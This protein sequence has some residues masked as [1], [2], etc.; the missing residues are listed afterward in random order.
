MHVLAESK[1]GWFEPLDDT[2][3]AVWAE[4][5]GS[6][7]D[8]RIEIPGPGPHPEVQVKH[9]LGAGK[10]LGAAVRTSVS[11]SLPSETYQVRFLVDLTSPL[12]LLREVADGLARL[13]TGRGEP[14]PTELADLRSELGASHP[15]WRRLGIVQC[16][17][18]RLEDAGTR[19]A[20]DKLERVLAPG[21]DATVAWKILSDDALQIAARQG[22]RDRGY[23]SELLKSAGFD[24]RPVGKNAR[25]HDQL[26]FSR[27]LGMRQQFIPMLTHLAQLE[28]DLTGQ[29]SGPRVWYRLYA[30]RANAELHQSNPSGAIE[31]ARRALDSVPDGVEA[32]HTL[33][34]AAIDLGRTEEAMNYARQSVD[35]HPENEQAWISMAAACA[36][37]GQPSPEP[38]IPIA[39]SRRFRIALCALEVQAGSW[40]RVV[41]LTG[42]LIAE[43]REEHELL[44]W[45]AQALHNTAEEGAADGRTRR[46]DA[47]RLLTELI[48]RVGDPSSDV[49]RM[50][51]VVRGMARASLGQTDLAAEDASVA[52][53]HHPDAPDV[54]R[55]A[56]LLQNRIGDRK[57]ALELLRHPAVDRDPA[58]LVL[59][60][61]AL[62]PDDRSS[63]QR[64]LDMALALLPAATRDPDF[65]MSAAIVAIDLGN[66]ALAGEL[67][68]G[69]EAPGGQLHIARGLLAVAEGRYEEGEREF[70]AAADLRPDRRAGTLTALAFELL[71][72]GAREHGLRVLEDL[73]EELPREARRRYVRALLDHGAF[74]RAS[75]V[76]ERA[77]RE[78][79]PP[80]WALADAAVLALRRAD[81]EGA[82]GFF[83]ALDERDELAIDGRIRL[84]MAL[85]QLGRIDTALPHLD[86]LRGDQALSDVQLM[87]TAELHAMIDR[88]DV[89]IPL[90]YRAARLAPGDPKIQRAFAGMT[91]MGAR[92]WPSPDEVGPDTHVILRNEH[93]STRSYTILSEPPIDLQ[94][95]ELTVDEARNRGVLGMRLG[96]VQVDNIGAGYLEQHWTVIRITPA[97]VAAAHD[98]AEHY[99]ERFPDEPFFMR[100]FQLSEGSITEF[101]PFIRS[102]EENRAHVT[103]LL[104]L[105]LDQVVPLG[106]LGDRLNTGIA[107]LVE[108]LSSDPLVGKLHVEWID[109]AGQ[110]AA[111]TAATNANALVLTRSA[112]ATA[113]RLD[114]L[115]VLESTYELV[116]PTSLVIEVREEAKKA[117][118]EVDEGRQRMIPDPAVGFAMREVP[119]GDPTLVA[120]RESVSALLAWLE[121][122]KVRHV[123]RPASTVGPADSE[124]EQLREPFGPSS[125]D[126]LALTRAHE[127]LL[128]ADDLGL[129]RFV[130][131]SESC[132]SLTLLDVLLEREQLTPARRDELLLD[133]VLR[134]YVT[135]RPTADLLL[136]ALRRPTLSA[137]ELVTVFDL[138]AAP[139][140]TLREASEIGAT[141]IR[142]A[143]D[144]PIWRPSTS[145]VTRLILRSMA[146]TFGSARAAIALRR[147]TAPKLQFLPDELAAVAET[148]AEAIAKSTQLPL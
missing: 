128:Y 55:L 63:A 116:A 29:D 108:A 71:D 59:R 145:A 66:A 24:V 4:T 3:L 17:V 142:R 9:G 115:S 129:R 114:L 125:F 138:L 140:L 26:D 7:D 47:V 43:G 42:K 39:A 35:S 18:E 109:A 20:L 110:H 91:V 33:T 132:S 28:R 2:P 89:A 139:V 56:V 83:Q 31:S 130:A 103:N 87:E 51:L 101:L 107:D 45:R 64:A 95:G 21:A 30:Q 148:C 105:Y 22:R 79:P 127:G 136:L 27:T 133:Q 134:R 122:G 78:T 5:G 93:G 72:A 135:V 40:Q 112:L 32:L 144:A 146:K 58:L 23:L 48:D 82:V 98:V 70:R 117:L 137:G 75:N 46:L 88:S 102:M 37:T 123:P 19:H 67:L 80:A 44:L 119:A 10:D 104:R 61:Q 57:E 11:R 85:I 54:I 13:R 81:P 25:W 96:S 74:D 76:I 113:Q 73:G 124:L 69:L 68:G 131:P 100:G 49:T 38:P 77:L 126:A 60:A 121:S 8:I 15:I 14:L 143:L 41:D 118:K 36:A 94:R 90:A 65:R 99:V 92:N 16:D 111:R 50:A 12:R 84:V 106:V 97:A 147:E 34:S 1:L 62:A 120:R 141:V 86:R 53:Q 6:G 52:Q